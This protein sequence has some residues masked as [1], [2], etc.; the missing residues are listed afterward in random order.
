MNG[1]ET[2]IFVDSIREIFDNLSVSL[3]FHINLTAIKFLNF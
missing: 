3:L 1:E 2:V